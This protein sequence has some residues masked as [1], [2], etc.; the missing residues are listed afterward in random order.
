MTPP[1]VNTVRE[2]ILY[3]YAKL[4]SRSSDGAPQRGSVAD[5]FGELRNGGI[6]VSRILRELE[7]EEELPGECVYCGSGTDLSADHLIPGNRGGSDSSDDTVI[8]C[9]SCN[10][11]KGDK[12]VFEWL[13]LE[14]KD[15]LHRLVAG[16]YLKQLY[17]LH[18]EAGTLDVSKHRLS[19][20]CRSCSLADVCSEWE[21]EGTLTCFCLESILPGEDKRPMTK[22][23]ENVLSL[24]GRTPMVK[25]K[26]ISRDIPGEIW[27]KLEYYNPSGSVK[28]R[29]ALFM[30][31]EAERK[32]LISPG[33]TIVEPT[34]GN[35]GIGLALVCALKG[36]NMIAV[37]PEAASKER[38]TMMELLGAKV[39]SVPCTHKS[40]GIT[41][42][43]I[44]RTM[45]RANEVV[46]Q[47]P[48]AF[49]PN[50]FE[51]SD[52][53]LM[54]AR[55][56]A[57]EILEQTHGK[58]HAYV[59]A[60]GT[61]GTFSGVSRILKEK[62]PQIKRVVVEP[63]GS[64]VISGGEPGFHKIQGIGEGFIPGVMDTSLAD[65]VVQ[66]SDDDAIA[67]MKRL[68]R[69]EGVFSGISGGANVVAAIKI[70]KMV[71]E[72]SII[73]T[74]IP[75]NTLRYYSTME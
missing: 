30:I 69:E 57:K 42:E 75:D 6:T 33:A 7:Q 41:K 23:L 12:G 43:D 48:N 14:R 25:L 67:M 8:T 65:E 68:A 18:E 59:A 73:V 28:D 37:M 9:R 22:P 15:T 61:G 62:R 2:E 11:A 32:G 72:D 56:T 55:T 45:E 38:R 24:I 21:A 70:G 52:N 58:F 26:R 34:S 1:Y 47:H 31:E 44:V 49:M 20:L 71:S 40:R 29:I 46:Q 53:P 35:T 64:P 60:C 66:V 74:V 3:E 4:I 39:E 27:A 63:E 10:A 54:H 36:Y 19:I 13:G 17:T 50:Q 51:N 5:R 16:K